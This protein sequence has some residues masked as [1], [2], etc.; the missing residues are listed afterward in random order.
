MALRPDSPTQPPPVTTLV[1]GAT[2]TIGQHLLR[3]LGNDVVVTSRNPAKAKLAFPAARIVSWD[4]LSALPPGALDGVDVIFHLAGEPVAEGRWTADKKRRIRESRVQSTR[5]L[6][7]AFAKHKPR[8]LISG[9]AVGIYGDRGDELLTEDSAPGSGFLASVCQAWEA[10]ALRAETLGVRVV[11]MRIGVVLAHEGGAL[12]ALLPLFKSGLAGTLGSGKQWMPWIHIDDVIGLLEL[13][14]KDDRVRGPL[15]TVAPGAVTNKTFTRT[16][17]A[18]LHRPTL[19]KAP[20]FA[21]R[22]AMG[23]K[24]EII[25]ASQRVTPARALALGYRFHHDGLEGALHTLLPP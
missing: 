20:L 21:M 6:V 11:T 9:S 7:D 18:V 14:A 8:V 23:E 3:H 24:A 17:G 10:E 22:L 12:P 2:G 5:A 4:G 15:N 16:L 13:A 1:T 25:L 19:L